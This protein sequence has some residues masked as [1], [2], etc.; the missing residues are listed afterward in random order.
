MLIM[1][2]LYKKKGR[3]NIDD[4]FTFISESLITGQFTLILKL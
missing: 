2:M 3:T 4:V 1:Y